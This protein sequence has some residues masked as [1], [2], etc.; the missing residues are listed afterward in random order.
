MT[1]QSRVTRTSTHVSVSTASGFQ[2]SVVSSRHVS[3]RCAWHAPPPRMLDD[4]MMKYGSKDWVLTELSA[5]VYRDSDLEIADFLAYSCRLDAPKSCVIILDVHRTVAE[6]G[7][8]AS[9]REKIRDHDHSM[10]P[11]P[12]RPSETCP[13]GATASYI[14]KNR[15]D[16]AMNVVRIIKFPSKVP[17]RDARELR[18]GQ[19]Y[20]VAL[21]QGPWAWTKL[22]TRS[23][24]GG[25]HGL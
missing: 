16:R 12:L 21:R 22:F 13:S 7:N 10:L 24:L 14:I 8:L 3:L 19:V 18:A 20:F 25:H 4:A 5:P 9:V 17:A 6:L 1:Q 15:T 23:W 2:C 11:Y